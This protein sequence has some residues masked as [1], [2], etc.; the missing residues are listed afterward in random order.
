MLSRGTVRPLHVRRGTAIA[1]FVL[2]V[3]LLAIV[4]GLTFFFGWVMMHKHQVLVANRYSAWQRVDTGVWPGEDRLNSIAFNNR[5]SDVVLSSEAPVGE[6]ADE[7][8][9]H[10][11]NISPRAEVLAE[12][13]ITEQYPT[14]L[15]AHVSADFNPR[16][17]LWQNVM[18]G[19]YDIHHRHGREGVTWRRGEVSCWSVLRNQY[20]S[21][22][23]DSL[24]RVSSPADGMAQMIRGLYLTGW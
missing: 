1:E 19:M 15:R 12:E 6:T 7:L 23:D 13:L 14:G 18:D 11:G 10:A 16:Q 9:S 22:L 8:I 21:E 2:A 20:Y 17:A 5:A 4:L 24:E 3:P